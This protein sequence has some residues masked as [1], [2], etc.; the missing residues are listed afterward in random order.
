[1]AR[2]SNGLIRQIPPASSSSRRTHHLA[3][4]SSNIQRE[5][6]SDLP[7]ILNPYLAV[8]LISPSLL[9]SP[10]LILFRFFQ[11]LFVSRPSLVSS[12]SF[13]LIY[14]L[15]SITSFFHLSSI[16]H[17]FPFYIV[18]FLYL[19]YSLPSPLLLF[20]LTFPFLFPSC[21]FPIP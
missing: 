7:L 10:C 5:Q 11:C 8:P 12:F 19:V 20:S 18:S 15:Y 14:V 21:P 17:F 2:M 4:K 9:S 1:M 16:F 13:L 3:C 6:G